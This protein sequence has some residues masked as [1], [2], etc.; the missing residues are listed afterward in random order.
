MAFGP[1][2]IG[3]ARLIHLSCCKDKLS[4]NNNNTNNNNNKKKYNEIMIR[5]NRNST[6]TSFIRSND[7]VY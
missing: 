5:K 3:Q 1:Q 4:N 2:Q 7:I 6:N